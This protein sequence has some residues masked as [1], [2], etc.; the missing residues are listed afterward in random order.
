MDRTGRTAIVPLGMTLGTFLVVTYILCVLY[1]LLVSDAGMHRL[2][3]D[4]LPGFT[5][6]TWPSFF[7]GLVWSFVFG[8]YIAVV[9]APIHN[10]FIARAGKSG[11]V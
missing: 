6:I 7:I 1:G 10:F 3:S 11:T 5:W 4:L 8:W 2:L 9:F